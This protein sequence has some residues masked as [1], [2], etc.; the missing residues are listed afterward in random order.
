MATI[1]IIILYFGNQIMAQN[2]AY[3]LHSVAIYC[4]YVKKYIFD[5][6]RCYAF[7]TDVMECE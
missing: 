6:D 7:A 1:T 3:Y 2:E 5:H 4:V